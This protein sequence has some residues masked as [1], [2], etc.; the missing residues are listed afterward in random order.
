M[1]VSTR[2]D[3]RSQNFSIHNTRRRQHQ[4]PRVPTCSHRFLGQQSTLLRYHDAIIFFLTIAEVRLNAAVN[5]RACMNCACTATTRKTNTKGREQR[6]MYDRIP[7]QFVESV[8]GP[9]QAESKKK[10]RTEKEERTGEV[11]FRTGN[12]MKKRKR[13]EE[14]KRRRDEETRRQ[15]D[16]ERRREGEKERKREREKERKCKRGRRH[17]TGAKVRCVYCIRL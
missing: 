7:A 2:L 9:N 10:N 14:T 17:K 5:Q 8:P 15:G 4:C 11:L 1:V 6:I 13:D 16:K 12:R 3:V